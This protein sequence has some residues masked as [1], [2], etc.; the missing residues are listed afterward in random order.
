MFLTGELFNFMIETILLRRGLEQNRLNV[1]PQQGEPIYTTDTQKFYIGDGVTPGGN[2]VVGGSGGSGSG[3]FSGVTSLNGLLN[4]IVI[5]GLSGVNITSSGQFLLISVPT[6]TGA[7]LTSGQADLRYYS[8]TNPNNFANS[9]NISDLSGYFANNPSGYVTQSQTGILQPSGNYY[10]LKSNPSGYLNTSTASQ[11]GFI[12]SV[13]G[14]INYYNIN[15]GNLDS[16]NI[17]ILQNGTGNYYLNSNPSGYIT[18]INS[19][20]FVQ[21][22]QTGQFY[23]ASNPSGFITGISTGSLT[24]QFYPLNSNPS[25]YIINS[26]SGII[27]FSNNTIILPPIPVIFRQGSS[28]ALNGTILASGEPGWTTD[29]NRLVIGDSLTSGGISIYKPDGRNIYVSKSLGKDTARG[30][31]NQYD[32]SVPFLTLSAANSI[33]SAGDTIIALDGTFN[34]TSLLLKSNVSWFFNSNANISS[35]PTAVPNYLF[36]D[37]GIP[38]TGVVIAGNGQ[39]FNIV[40]PPGN[41][42][43]IYLNGSSNVTVTDINFLTSQ[44]FSFPVIYGVYLGGN[45]N[46]FN[47]YGNISTNTTITSVALGVGGNN[48]TV[49]IFG[50]LSASGS[51]TNG[52]QVILFSS[53]NIVNVNGSVVANTAINVAAAAS[54]NLITVGSLQDITPGTS[55]GYSLAIQNPQLFTSSITPTGIFSI[56]T[57]FGPQDQYVNIINTGNIPSGTYKFPLE[58]NSRIGQRISI[59]TN[60]TIP[61]FLVTGN[62]VG[63]QFLGYN[64]GPLYPGSIDFIKIATGTWVQEG[65]SSISLTG[66][67]YYPASGNPAGYLTGIPN[68]PTDL[69][70][71]DSGNIFTASNTFSANGAASIPALSISGIVFA[72]G[73]STTTVPLFLIQS[74]NSTAVSSWNT[75][76][77]QIGINCASVF[78]GNLIDFH[79]NGGNTLFNVGY[80]GNVSSFNQA[81]DSTP[82]FQSFQ[83]NRPAGNSQMFVFGL[84]NSTKNY[85]QLGINIVSSTSTGNNAQFSIEGGGFLKMFGNGFVQVGSQGNPFYLFQLGGSTSAFP[86][87]KATGSILQARLANDSADTTFQAKSFIASNGNNVTA[88]VPSIVS[89]ITGINSKAT[90]N[91]SIYTVP[92]G[93]TFIPLNAIIKVD[94][95]IGI[96]NGP[97]VN[98]FTNTTGDIYVSTALNALSNSGQIFGFNTFGM[99]MSVTG[100]VNLGLTSIASGTSQTISVDLIGYLR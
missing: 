59:S 73:T 78:S 26:G 31:A 71:T 49:N 91:Y 21:N 11:A 36:T 43:G 95:A 58:L 2:L 84:N 17:A 54:S 68:L 42:Y 33:A 50:N 65:N 88:T 8:I 27:D 15:S 34:D 57:G 86:A 98:V 60:S 99:S 22:G 25:G 63:Q 66:L 7:G 52:V 44:G 14:N 28:A 77:T 9:G 87:L 100:N 40:P 29:T 13:Y 64:P 30:S 41:S 55:W 94:S 45:N 79:A 37:S 62:T 3:S 89:T 48:N 74:N 82:C 16:I 93:K 6:S 10:P 53:G 70:Y 97:T 35:T 92:S 61:F 4:N 67:P 38:A 76:G 81:T 5:S 83:P 69:A 80:L 39:T 20:I 18:G 56:T 46:S 12:T 24:G 19:G 1:I 51:T 47:M 96:T 32:P 72:G 85:A 23:A 90:G 75:N